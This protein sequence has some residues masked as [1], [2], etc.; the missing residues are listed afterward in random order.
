MEPH[1]KISQLSQFF[2]YDTFQK[3]KKF[4]RESLYG[5]K[6]TPYI[7]SIKYFNLV[8]VYKALIIISDG[9]LSDTIHLCQVTN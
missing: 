4:H 3:K 1:Q 6:A 8:G 2:V 5:P 7:S 9:F